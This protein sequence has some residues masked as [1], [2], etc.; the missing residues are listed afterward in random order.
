MLDRRRLL[1][2]EPLDEA[3][4]ATGLAGEYAVGEAASEGRLN[5]PP[6]IGDFTACR[7]DQPSSV[8]FDMPAGASVGTRRPG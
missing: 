2:N 1:Q 4:E 5:L 3:V 6:A 7:H 8:I